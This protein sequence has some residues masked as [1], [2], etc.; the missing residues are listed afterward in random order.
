VRCELAGYFEPDVEMIM[1][2][3][4]TELAEKLRFYLADDAARA[5]LRTAGL[6]RAL[7]CH[8]YQQRYAALFTHLGIG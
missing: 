7:S 6:R 5:K 8:T 4:V 3:D 2:R 1:W